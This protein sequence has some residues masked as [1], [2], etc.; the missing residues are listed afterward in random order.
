MQ[1]WPWLAERHAKVSSEACGHGG[2]SATM[3]SI[4]VVC[5][6][7]S[8]LLIASCQTCM[9]RNLDAACPE[10]C[11]SRSVEFDVVCFHSC[12]QVGRRHMTVGWEAFLL[13][14]KALWLEPLCGRALSSSFEL[15]R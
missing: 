8:L 6:F 11:G 14:N 12:V 2:N 3:L 10:G 7:S 1:A 15:R 4:V 9:D 13:V 5:F